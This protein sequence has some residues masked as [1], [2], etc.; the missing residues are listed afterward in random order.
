MVRQTRRSTLIALSA[1]LLPSAVLLGITIRLLRQETELTERR[2][3]QARRAAALDFGR[4]LLGRLERADTG[5]ILQASVKA[6]SFALPWERGQPDPPAAFAQLMFTA[7]AAEQ[8]AAHVSADSLYG[9]AVNAASMPW[10]RALATLFRA[11]NLARAGDSRATALYTRL[12]ALPLSVQDEEGMPIALYAADKLRSG[13]RFELPAEPLSPPALLALREH[14][15]PEDSLKLLQAIRDAER[16]SELRADLEHLAANAPAGGWIAYGPEPWFVRIT[17]Q[18]TVVRAEP[19]LNGVAIHRQ[20]VDGAEP[21]GSA[22][23][24]LFAT[25]PVPPVE[26]DSRGL[27]L[28]VTL[29]T[30]AITSAA[31]YLAWRDVNREVSAAELR[32]HFVSSVSHELKTPLTSIRMYAELLRM[33]PDAALAVREEY[34]STIVSESERLSRLI[35][36]VLDFSRL[37]R[38][39]KTYQLVPV[40]LGRLVHEIERAMSYPL[41]QSGL[42]L[43]VRVQSDLP[44]VRADADAL[45][46]AVLNLLS[47][48]MKFRGNS[49]QIDLV[50]ERTNGCASIRVRDRG[51][52]ISPAD[53]KHVFEKFYR[54]PDAEAAGIP[55]TGLGLA[56]VA[57]IA[58]AHGGSVEVES[59][60]GQG[61]T[62]SIHLPLRSA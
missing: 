19:L 40:S 57:H 39:E 12:Q 31:A 58:Q 38:G 32:T 26:A 35:N 28:L 60:V 5:L 1:L 36:N 34:L 43:Q 46:Q 10:Q 62:F 29:L 4:D 47:N 61:S 9:S 53:Q 41:A 59:E 2:Q 8:R 56:L 55:G 13:H 33:K 17:D 42:E 20:P 7:S 52:G 18:V 21:V 3:A 11:R 44:Q 25:L 23:P 45:S 51:R 6:G 16:L 14:I 27:L 30:I 54:T 22:F 37:E 50:V 24:G 15:E 48:A 49:S